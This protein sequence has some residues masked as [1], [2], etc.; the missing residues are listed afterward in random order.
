[1]AENKVL[2]TES[3]RKQTNPIRFSRSNVNKL[4]TYILLAI[5]SFVSLI[6]FLWMISTSLMNWT[7]A[8]GATVIPSELLWENYEIAWDMGQ[9]EEYFVNSVLITLIT[10]AGEL[11]FSILAAYAF[12][13]MKFP[14]RNLIFGILLSSMMIPGMVMMIP[15]F[16]I[17]TWIGRIASELT[18]YVLLIGGL[19]V[20]TAVLIFSLMG[21]IKWFREKESKLGLRAI[22]S[23][24]MAGGS[25]ST[26][27][28]SVCGVGGSVSL[29]YWIIS[30]WIGGAI[31]PTPWIDNW[32]ALTIPFMGSIFAIFLLRQFFAQIPDELFDAA[33]IDG[34]GHFRFLVQVVIP[35]SK[36]PIL[37][38]TVLS[39]IGSWN[40]LAWPLLVTNSPD[41]RP[42]AVGFLNFVSEAGQD[43]HY[44]MAGAVITIIPIL[45]LYFLTQR[46]FTESIARTGLK[47]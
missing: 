27:F 42:I 3:S 37:V 2:S 29:I 19:I 4:I 20:A 24:G 17:V 40:A 44:M 9:F 1:M 38:I 10:L 11:T 43:T 30:S 32:P 39:F 14:G 28:W 25:L 5:G 23:P 7:E 6:P 45:I 46:Q 26:F 34:A 35:L 8:T 33:R 47:G 12:A 13:R 22:I 31:E 36:A 16:L 18:T 21:L 15:N 41:W